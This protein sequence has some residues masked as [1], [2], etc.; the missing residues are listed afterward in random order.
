MQRLLVLLVAAFVGAACT[1]QPVSNTASSTVEPEP[2][3]T[4]GVA[5]PQASDP[6]ALVAEADGY[7]LTV[8]ADRETLAPGGTVEFTATFHNGTA[9]PIDVAGPAC[10]GGVTAFVFVRLPQE[11]A[12]KTWSGVRQRFKDY[13]LKQ[14]MGPGIVPALDPLQLNIWP[15]ECGE[16]TLSSELEAGES[17]TTR[18]SW[19][20]EIVAGVDAL[21]G[22]VPFSVSVGYD[23]QNGP[24]S[25]PPGYQG[26]R[27]SWVADFKQLAVQ[28][29]LEVVGTGRTLAGP[30]EVIDAALADKKYA[31]WL[32]ERPATTWSGANLFLGSMPAAEGILPK[33]PA[34]QLDLFREIGVPRHWAIAIIDPFDASLISVHYC[35]V[36]CDR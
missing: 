3:S 6:T 15:P 20:A 14:G 31:K 28:G 2:S 17:I 5:S 34:W 11:P 25:Y 23:I 18:M 36:P 13:V 4:S 30:G 22:A 1:A 35:D 26:P 10:S 24:P 9:D 27:G 32:A 7:T 12:G 21:A 33:G 29:E 16:W 8:T 19:K